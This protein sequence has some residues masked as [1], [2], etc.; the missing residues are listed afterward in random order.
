VTAR[1]TWKAFERS[2]AV[3]LGGRRIP[4]TG[5][6]R[7]DRDIESSLFWVQAKLRKSIPAWLFDWLGGICGVCPEG[8]IGI[9]ILRTPRMRNAEA[10]VVMRYGDF[11]DL[12]GAPGAGVSSTHAK[13]N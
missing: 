6:D 3:D 11:I 1:N 7:A 12:H 8:K 2:I 5:I 13:P 4:V 9:L 10:L